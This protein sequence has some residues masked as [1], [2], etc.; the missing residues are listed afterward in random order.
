LFIRLCLQ[1]RGRLSK[2][3]REQFAELTDDELDKL[4]QIVS[5]E[6]IPQNPD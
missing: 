2:A 6:I 4:E 3:K 1:G 5:E